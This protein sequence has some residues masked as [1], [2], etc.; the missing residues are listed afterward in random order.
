LRYF[1][2]EV[3][4]GKFKSNYLQYIEQYEDDE[5]I[6]EDF[7]LEMLLDEDYDTEQAEAYKALMGSKFVEDDWDGY[8]Q[9]ESGLDNDFVLPDQDGGDFENFDDFGSKDYLNNDREG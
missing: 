2:S 8:V 7:E 9:F 3:Y 5:S 4:K 1:V 6:Y